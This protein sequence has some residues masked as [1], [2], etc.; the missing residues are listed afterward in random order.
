MRLMR[1]KANE[2]TEEKRGRKVERNK[3]RPGRCQA[4]IA[5]LKWHPAGDPVVVGMMM[6]VQRRHLEYRC[7]CA[8]FDRGWIGF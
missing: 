2:A 7:F 6:D 3:D 1:R 8:L 5:R 4:A